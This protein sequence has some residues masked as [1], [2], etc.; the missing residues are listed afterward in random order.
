MLLLSSLDLAFPRTAYP[1]S[2]G[3]E[4][5]IRDGFIKQN[6]WFAFVLSLIG[7]FILIGGGMM[8]MFAPFGFG[9]MMNATRGMEATHTTADR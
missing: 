5:A 2:R 1:S 9:E 3:I 4:L 8:P 7:G 6:P